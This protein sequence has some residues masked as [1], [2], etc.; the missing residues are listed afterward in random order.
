ANIIK[1]IEIHPVQWIEEVLEI[2]LTE[3]PVPIIDNLVE[4]KES[5][6]KQEENA[7]NKVNTH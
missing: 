6:K 7:P 5:E 4:T 2:A 1:D 3:R